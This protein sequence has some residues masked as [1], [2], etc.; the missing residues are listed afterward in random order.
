MKSKTIRAPAQKV[1]IVDKL[2]PITERTATILVCVVATHA[3]IYDRHGIARRRRLGTKAF[4]T[5]HDAELRKLAELRQ[6]ATIRIPH[7]WD[8]ANSARKQLA[9]YT[10]T[11][12]LH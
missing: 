7:L 9:D 2:R 5:R 12:V 10:K 1:W 6:L 4:F 3:E 11:G 8:M